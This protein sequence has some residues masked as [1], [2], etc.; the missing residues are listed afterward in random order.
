MSPFFAA[1]HTGSQALP[2]MTLVAF[3]PTDEPMFTLIAGLAALGAVVSIS[4]REFLLPVWI[5]SIAVLDTRAFGSVASVPIALLAGVAVSDVLAP[6]LSPE[7]PERDGGA[8]SGQRGGPPRWLGGALAVA[9]VCYAAIGSLVAQ[10]LLMTAMSPDERDGMA[11]VAEHTAPSSRFLVVSGDRWSSDRT[12][13]W[14]P[15]LTG[16][17]SVATIQGTEWLGGNAFNAGRDDYDA[18]QRCHDS[19]GDCL[20]TW[21]SASAQPFDYV[22]I[23][24]LAPRWLLYADDRHECCAGL[25]QALRVDARYRV[26]FDGPGATVFER[27]S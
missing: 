24:R 12:S 5:V 26:V 19:D 8:P 17:T 1:V 23:P 21:A 18:L 25:R 9:A 2:L 14:F 16:R 22:Y 4:R 27:R 11:W 3:R 7:S 20:D 13:E 6:L 10:P 15:A